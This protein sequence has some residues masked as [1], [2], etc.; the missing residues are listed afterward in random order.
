MNDKEWEGYGKL[1]ELDENGYSIFNHFV[2]KIS[3]GKINGKGVKMHG[4]WKLFKAN[5]INGKKNGYGKENYFGTLLYEGEFVDDKK[6]GNGKEYREY[7]S[8]EELE[9]I[10]EVEFLNR[11]WWEGKGKE[12]SKFSHLFDY[13]I[14]EG[15][16]KKWKKEGEGK[17]Y[18]NDNKIK[19]EGN[20]IDAERNGERIE[21]FE[22]GKMKFK[23][24]FSKRLKLNGKGYNIVDE[25]IMVKDKLKYM[26]TWIIWN[27]KENI[28]LEKLGKESKMNI[29]RMVL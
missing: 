10:F 2:G 17:E 20:Y 24:Q 9:L 11:F 28:K 14:Y 1:D 16:Y 29:I 19:Y 8:N 12:Y 21:Y 23:S 7:R 13:L 22:N 5:F 25:V 6:C 26:I 18:Y 15:D 27:L 4:K 3:K